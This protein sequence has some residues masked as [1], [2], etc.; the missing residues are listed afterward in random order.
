MGLAGRVMNAPL[1]SIATATLCCTRTQASADFTFGLGIQTAGNLWHQDESGQI[2][3]F[4]GDVMK[5]VESDAG[6]SLGFKL[7]NTS[8]LQPLQQNLVDMTFFA[9]DTN[10]KNQ[11][12]PDWANMDIPLWLTR[13]GFH[14]APKAFLEGAFSGIVKKSRRPST[15]WQFASPF[16]NDLWLAFLLTFI[17]IV[18]INVSL[19]AIH[20]GHCR[21]AA[22][23]QRLKS[24]AP[25]SKHELGAAAWTGFSSAPKVF[26][27]HFYHT[28]VAM[29]DNGAGNYSRP[30]EKILHL[31]LLI[32]SLVFTATYT[33]NLAAHLTKPNYILGGPAHLAALKDST[34]CVSFAGHRA[35][36]APFVANIL[37]ACS[38]GNCSGA[39]TG[40][41]RNAWCHHSLETGAADI[42]VSRDYVLMQYLGSRGRC[43]SLSH[44][45]WL[46]IL[47]FSV[48]LVFNPMTSSD[49]WQNTSRSILGLIQTTEYTDILQRGLMRFTCP[50]SEEDDQLRAVSSHDM[51]GVFFLCGLFAVAAIGA[52]LLSC[53]SPKAEV[54]ER[55]KSVNA[56]EELLISLSKRLDDYQHDIMQA[57]GSM[58]PCQETNARH[59]SPVCEEVADANRCA[60]SHVL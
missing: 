55:G 50:R 20:S 42:W 4:L 1:L 7:F 35:R 23:L 41:E 15:F 52:A 22:G 46:S 38:D 16:A 40:D 49:L 53:V 32:L 57:L 45:Q 30:A 8:A 26:F 33:A 18:V 51:V 56:S 12:V 31:G 43:A 25:E 60:T 14:L 13:T 2:G 17:A 39:P 37:V 3:G 59:G 36:V 11:D 58:K 34:A 6:F 24:H 44:T 9:S 27:T 29:L 47:P 28:W 10:L 19:D 5:Y 21:P 54:L 48:N